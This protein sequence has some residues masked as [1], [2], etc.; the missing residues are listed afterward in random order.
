MIIYAY[1]IYYYLVHIIVGEEVIMFEFFKKSN[2]VSNNATT[3]ATSASAGKVRLAK[4]SEALERQVVNLSKKGF[5][6][7][8]HKA[9]VVLCLDRSGS[10]NTLFYNGGVQAAL[11]R[12]LPIALRFDDDGRLPVYV[13]DDIADHVP[14]AMDENNFEQFVKLE[15]IDKGYVPRGGTKYAPVIK[16]VIADYKKSKT[17]VFV[18]F[19]TDG[20]NCD[21]KKTDSMIIESS[22]HKIFFQFVGIGGS[23]FSY[24]KELDN[25]A[26]RECDNTA[27]IQVS[28]FASLT[29]E[30]LYQKLLEQYPQW[31]RAKGLK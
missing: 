6:I 26:G 5:D 10:M 15:I 8:A 24:L 9:Q 16:Q 14:E 12:L 1:K 30:Q 19:I 22:K 20:V 27:F 17:P 29:D 23:S 2:T 28:S 21:E 4:A 25:L 13:F 3:A 18:I 11:T 7:T 31:L